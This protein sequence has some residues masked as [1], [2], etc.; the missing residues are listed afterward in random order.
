MTEELKRCVNC[1]R[2]QKVCAGPCV[3]TIDGVDIKEHARQRQCPEGHFSQMGVIP[4]DWDPRD[5]E[6]D[7][8]GTGGCNCA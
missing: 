4:E 6:K 8:R 1:P 3:C 2:R 7:S 5:Y